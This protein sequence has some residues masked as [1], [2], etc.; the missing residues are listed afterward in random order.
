MTKAE[1][2]AIES[3][4]M[5][6][7]EAQKNLVIT[8]ANY[9]IRDQSSRW[10]KNTKEKADRYGRH[11]YAQAMREAK[12]VLNDDLQKETDLE[13]YSRITKDELEVA[14]TVPNLVVFPTEKDYEKG[15]FFRYFITRYDGQTASEVNGKLFK[16]ADK[17]WPE[18]MYQKARVRWYIK[19]GFNYE[20]GRKEMREVNATTLNEDN[21]LIASETV[22]QLKNTIK[23]FTQFIR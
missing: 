13:V 20:S 9:I 2:I 1:I 11:V 3:K 19:E 22:P 12:W 21:I 10:F 8:K 17:K 15:Y 7:T 14:D 4:R 23:D 16:E 6:L 18:P 5:G